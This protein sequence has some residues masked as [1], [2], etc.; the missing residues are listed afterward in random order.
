MKG[1]WKDA[2]KWIEEAAAELAHREEEDDPTA[3]PTPPAP[4]IATTIKDIIYNKDNSG[5]TL[6]DNPTLVNLTKKVYNSFLSNASSL[7][8]YATC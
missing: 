6:P 8:L 3:S 7:L 1:T 5:I 4:S 2:S